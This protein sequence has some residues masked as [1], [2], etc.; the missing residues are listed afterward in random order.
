LACALPSI[1]SHVLVRGDFRSAI[2]A[3][4]RHDDNR[5][6]MPRVGLNRS[7]CRW[8]PSRL[9]WSTA[10]RCTEKNR[11]GMQCAGLRIPLLSVEVAAV[12]PAPGA[13]PEHVRLTPGCFQMFGVLWRGSLEREPRRREGSAYRLEYAV[14]HSRRGRPGHRAEW[15][16]RTRTGIGRQTGGFPH[17]DARGRQRGLAGGPWGS[18][19]L[20]PSCSQ[21]RSVS[22]WPS[23]SCY[24]PSAWR[25]LR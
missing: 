13:F 4:R 8:E 2:L 16:H 10:S 20:R 21:G 14:A 6:G 1:D 12:P 19:P 3:L 23:A 18:P 17:S 5:Q 22:V 11:R 15:A 24:L 9:T 25:C 7:R